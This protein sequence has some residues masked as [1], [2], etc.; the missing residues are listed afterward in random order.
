MRLCKI[1]IAKNIKW[2]T[3]NA[4]FYKLN[5]DGAFS[6]NTAG[7]RGL[8]RNFKAEWKLGFSDSAPHESSTFADLY[9]LTQG[10]KLA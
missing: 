9:A 10:L 5:I 3:P 8:I 7:I 6:D 2:N 1:K 4:Q